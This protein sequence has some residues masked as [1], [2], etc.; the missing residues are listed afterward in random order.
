MIVTTLNA[1]SLT[2]PDI[3][4]QIVAPPSYI[5]GVPTDVIGL[6][7]TASWG[8]VNVPTHMGNGQ[9]ATLNFGSMSAAS[10]TDPHDM[11]TDLFLAFGQAGT[12][13]SLEAWGVRVSD[14]TDTAAAGVV[15]GTSAPLKTATI[16]G[17]IANN[18]VLNI[19]FTS[20][21]IAGSPLTISVTAS[22]TDTVTTLAA[23]FVTK[24]NANT[25]LAA[26]NVFAT[27]LAG[28]ISIYSSAAISPAI[29]Y[30]QSVS[31]G[32]ETITLANGTSLASGIT[33]TAK[34]TGVLGNSIAGVITAG[35][36]ANSF[37]FTLVP[38]AG[39]S[40]V[41][42]NIP[43]TG[44]WPALQAAINSGLNGVRGRSQYVT[45]SN[46]NV[47]VGAPTVQ[48]NA[49]AGG[50]DGRAGVTTANLLGSNTAFPYTGLWALS[51]VNPA[52]GIGWIVGLTDQAAP[53]SMLP[54]GQ[55]NAVSV[56]FSMME[57]QTTAQKLTAVQ[58]IGIADPSFLY[59]G[60]WI[61]M[62]D[63]VNAVTRLVPSTAVIG[64][65]WATLNPSQSALNNP[66][67]MVVGTE[68]NN[69]V[70]GTI[71]Y[72]ESE[73]GQLNSAGIVTITNPVPGGSFFGVRTGAST[74]ANPAT[75][76][77]EYWRMTAFL[78]RSL[79]QAMGKFVGKNQSQQPNDPLRN[80]VR[81][82]LNAF[83][84]FL[85][86]IGEIDSAIN[87]CSFSS[88]PT[89][90]PGMGVNTA[91][92]VAEHYLFALSQVTYLSSVWFFIMQLQGGT[93]V[94]TVASGQNVTPPG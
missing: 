30:T 45:A 90:N 71:P 60:D 27:N 40:E 32:S 65:M 75:A 86:G 84:S 82:Q 19:I 7:G 39:T 66:V 24:I 92:S 31:P 34:C 94:V 23:K 81:S 63:Q 62:Y 57:G 3:Y 44:F 80:A 13:G 36:Q 38:F 83:T 89:A 64:G 10:L 2:A 12:T 17:S 74:S 88:S 93:T 73:V 15:A 76:P 49:L 48:S 14:G 67:N 70:S 52:V 77:M 8:Y 11:P 18:D 51:G 46:A 79:D 21:A 25:V 1:A 58:T 4:T 50:T 61:Y 56:F 69:P 53:S 41:Y 87:V 47:A 28:V 43:A 29:T 16:A 59:S 20:S 9:D 54:F 5:R 35:A 42:S 33:L 68:R 6:V 37:T 26:L 91:S 78:A 72:T 55:S 85:V 22:G